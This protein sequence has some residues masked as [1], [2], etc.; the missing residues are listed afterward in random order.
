MGCRVGALSAHKG[1]V[2]KKKVGG[3]ENLCECNYFYTEHCG[4]AT[5]VEVPRFWTVQ[6]VYPVMNFA[7]IRPKT[8][9]VKIVAATETAWILAR[10][11]RT[12]RTQ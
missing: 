2:C 8:P 10:W 9:M 12:S 11:R 3:P 7:V 5:N 1:G 6:L 4:S